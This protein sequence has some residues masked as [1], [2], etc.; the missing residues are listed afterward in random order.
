MEF[1]KHKTIKRKQMTKDSHHFLISYSENSNQAPENNQKDKS[2]RKIWLPM[3]MALLVSFWLTGMLPSAV[4]AQTYQ[5]K[6]VQINGGGYV[7]D[8]IYSP[9]EQNL[10]Y[11]RTDV[12]GAYR[13]EATNKGDTWTR[14]NMSN[15]LGGNEGCWAAGELL[16]VDPNLGSILLLGSS[17]DRLWKS[18]N[19]GSSWNKV[20]SFPISTSP[21]GS[22]C[23]SFVLFDKSSSSSD[24]ATSRVLSMR[25][26]C[27]RA[28]TYTI[29]PILESPGQHFLINLSI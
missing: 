27:R 9:S 12:G 25:V 24:T 16:Q 22:G 19:Y 20:N 21:S 3:W 23:I 6:S 28:L 13:W 8:I 15:K 10:I 2:K 17:T 29:V 18:T 26:Y 4:E 5:W 11:A 14:K 7:T 1:T